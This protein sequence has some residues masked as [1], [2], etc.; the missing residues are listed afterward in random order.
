MYSVVS[1]KY[2]HEE[3]T[4]STSGHIQMNHFVMKSQFA[5]CRYSGQIEVFIYCEQLHNYFAHLWYTELMA[6]VWSSSAGVSCSS[7]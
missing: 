3:E 7:K 2:L 6:D 1:L 4:L 5:D